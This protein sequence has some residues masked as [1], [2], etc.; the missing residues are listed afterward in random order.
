VVL[1]VDVPR[2]GLVVGVA[3][4]VMAVGLAMPTLVHLRWVRRNRRAVVRLV[5]E[6]GADWAA[7]AWLLQGAEHLG[8]AGARRGSGP[9][10]ILAV[11]GDRL[12][13][14]PNARAVRRGHVETTRPLAELHV[15]VDARR[16]MLTGP[17]YRQVHVDVAG[18]DVAGV[19]VA[20]RRAEVV[21]L[22]YAEAGDE[23]SAWLATGV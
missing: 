16:R 7:F 10:G 9:V 15:A 6:G 4:V 14:L 19:D 2:A 13:W 21:A 20:R 8:G 5:R 18:V 3:V 12:T 11:T 17:R 23:P 22:L 1:T